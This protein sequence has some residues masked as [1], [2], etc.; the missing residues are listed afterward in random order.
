MPPVLR[1]HTKRLAATAEPASLSKQMTSGSPGAKPL[2]SSSSSRRTQPRKNTTVA[3][4]GF[5][6]NE[7]DVPFP[8][9]RRPLIKPSLEKIRREAVDQG[10]PEREIDD[11]ASFTFSIQ[12]SVYNYH[13]VAEKCRQALDDPS[14]C[15]VSNMTRGDGSTRHYQIMPFSDSGRYPWEAPYN[16]PKIK[17]LCIL[18]SLSMRELSWY[19][20]GYHMPVPPTRAER[21]ALMKEYMGITPNVDAQYLLA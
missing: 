8:F 4:K 21:I 14:M 2:A 3:E 7:D 11:Y 1:S 17:N 5:A 12:T 18:N 13:V 16:L 6:E 15:R 19:L 9:V 10:I 20:Q